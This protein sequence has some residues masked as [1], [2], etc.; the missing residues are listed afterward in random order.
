MYKANLSIAISSLNVAVLFNVLQRQLPHTLRRASLFSL[1]PISKKTSYTHVHTSSAHIIYHWK[2]DT[3][4]LSLPQ[5][6]FVFQLSHIFRTLINV[7]YQ[8]AHRLSEEEAL[9]MSEPKNSFT[10]F[11]LIYERNAELLRLRSSSC[12][13]EKRSQLWAFV[14]NYKLI[15]RQ[16][17]LL[18]VRERLK[19]CVRW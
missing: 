14:F 18:R 6:F 16:F 10:K 9:F 7:S 3:V 17:R 12:V 1:C 15:K 13:M 11:N 5:T 4:L 8:I 2:L 19:L